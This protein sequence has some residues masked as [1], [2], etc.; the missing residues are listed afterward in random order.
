MNT[1]KININEADRKELSS[2][3][4]IGAEKADK[5]VHYREEKGDFNS[6]DELQT[7]LNIS[8]EQFENLKKV[9]EV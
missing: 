9:L 4:G 3:K 5:I 7:Q 6:I 8:D 1:Y 2:V